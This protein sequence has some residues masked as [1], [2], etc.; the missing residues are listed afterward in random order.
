M[1]DGVVSSLTSSCRAASAAPGW[2]WALISPRFWPSYTKPGVTT[3][4]FLYQTEESP[5]M[6]ER[7]LVS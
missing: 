7:R 2:L 1:T 4:M 5:V 6:L 3:P